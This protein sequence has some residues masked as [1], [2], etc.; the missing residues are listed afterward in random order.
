[1]PYAM[2]N[3]QLAQYHGDEARLDV[4]REHYQLFPKSNAIVMKPSAEKDKPG[5]F[6]FAAPSHIRNF[7][8]CVRSRKEP[9]APVEVGQHTNVVLGMAVESLR[10]GRRFRWDA[11][12]QRLQ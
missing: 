5:S 3:D 1:M 10:T 9:N 6:A 8:E 4:G 11:A 2:H 7:L 12:G